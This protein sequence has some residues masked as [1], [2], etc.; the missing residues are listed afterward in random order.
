MELKGSKTAKNL[1]T[2]FSAE[3]M[4]RVK[5]SLYGERARTDGYEEIGDIFDT[6]SGNEYAHARLLL[7]SMLGKGVD[8]LANLNDSE[9]G[10]NFEQSEMYPS[11]AT[12]AESEGFTDIAQTFRLLAEIE[13]SHEQIY[14]GLIKK[15]EKG[16]VFKSDKKTAWI[17]LNCGHIYEGTEPPLR[18]PTCSHP[19]SYFKIKD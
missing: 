11:Y 10:E 16:E 6:I 7:R 9:R 8:T 5:Y 19:Q 18:C 13:K 12:V 2:A 3:C 15:M 4:A 14:S 17:C 1:M